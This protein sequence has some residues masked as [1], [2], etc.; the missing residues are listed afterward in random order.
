MEH[1]RFGN[2]DLMVSRIGLGAVTAMSGAYGPVD[3]DQIRRC[4]SRQTRPLP[5]IICL[6][7][8]H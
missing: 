6:D 7:S 4:Y 8:L 5:R 1:R 3:D 2:T